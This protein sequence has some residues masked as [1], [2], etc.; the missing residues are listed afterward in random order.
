MAGNVCEKENL[1]AFRTS[2]IWNT[3][4]CLFV[5]V[6]PTADCFSIPFRDAHETPMYFYADPSIPIIRHQSVL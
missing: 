1:D 6:S 3:P 4:K 2:T 5:K